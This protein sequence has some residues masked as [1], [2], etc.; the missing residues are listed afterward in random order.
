MKKKRAA[1]RPLKFGE[2]TTVIG[3]RVPKNNKKLIEEIKHHVN[4]KLNAF[5]K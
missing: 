4:G 3:F 5:I 2:E 1:N